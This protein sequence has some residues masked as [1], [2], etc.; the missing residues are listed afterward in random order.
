MQS[1]IQCDQIWR[2]FDTLA[3]FLFLIWQNAEPTLGEFD[4]LSGK[5]SMLPMAKYW[6]IIEPSGHTAN[7]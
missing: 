7:I 5:L 2:N 1:N 4:T 6:K 3:I